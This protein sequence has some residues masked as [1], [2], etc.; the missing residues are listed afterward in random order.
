MKI[1]F[2]NIWGGQIF[3]PL[4]KFIK[5]QMPQTDFFCFQEMLDS[6]A[7]TRVP[8]GGHTN[9]RSELNDS[10]PELKTLYRD[11]YAP[12]LCEWEKGKSYNIGPILFAKKE[13]TIEKQGTIQIH[14]APITSRDLQYL[15]FT[16]NGKRYTLSNLHGISQPYSKLDS[17]ERLLQSRKIIDFLKN[18]KGENI[19]GGDFNLLPETESIRALESTGM[20]NLIEE[21]KIHSTRNKFS[22]AKYPEAQRQYFSDYVFVSPGVRVLHFAIP[23]V[24]VSD[25]LP[26]ILEFN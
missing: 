26:M 11:F 9:I 4:V 12:S 19:I 3:D 18:Q 24:E 21:Y 6:A 20:K 1:I 17:P 23:E 16:H 2:L 22:L 8:W 5:E 25:H 10:I 7:S 13:I 15:C 14:N